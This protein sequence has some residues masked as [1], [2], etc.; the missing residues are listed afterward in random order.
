MSRIISDSGDCS[1][2]KEII[3]RDD[4]PVGEQMESLEPARET[5]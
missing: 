5:S 3:N 2:E 1:K 4:N